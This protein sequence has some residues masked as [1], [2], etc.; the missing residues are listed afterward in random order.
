MVVPCRLQCSDIYRYHYPRAC[1]FLLFHSITLFL[2][3]HV[4]LTCLTFSTCSF[5][6]PSEQCKLYCSVEGMTPNYYKL[7]HRVE[8]GTKCMSDGTDVCVNGVCMVSHLTFLFIIAL[9]KSIIFGNQ[10]DD[11]TPTINCDF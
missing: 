11:T 2:F 8:D 9:P 1:L 6:V 3:L 5:I 4:H 10:L 7:Q